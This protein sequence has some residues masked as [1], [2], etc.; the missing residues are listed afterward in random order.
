MNSKSYE[1][2][3]PKLLTAPSVTVGYIPVSSKQTKTQCLLI[4][5]LEH[6]SL[7]QIVVF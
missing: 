7:L 5:E 4:S 1:L 6:P 2:G 3:G